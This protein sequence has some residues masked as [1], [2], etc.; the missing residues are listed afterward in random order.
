MA[1]EVT[2]NAVANSRRRLA[3]ALI[4]IVGG[5]GFETVLAN[6]T[7]I[8]VERTSRDDSNH[9]DCED[10]L[11]PQLAGSGLRMSRVRALVMPRQGIGTGNRGN[12]CRE[13]EHNGEKHPERYS[14]RNFRQRTTRGGLGGVDHD[15]L[16]CLPKDETTLEQLI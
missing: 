13:D 10:V 12:D 9:K 7:T 2:A 11:E 1:G 16:P 5:P 3:D 15:A 14:V 8:S 6:E 4:G